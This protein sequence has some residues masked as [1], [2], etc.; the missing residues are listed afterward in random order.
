MISPP[1]VKL[2]TVQNETTWVL[3]HALNLALAQARFTIVLKVDCDYVLDPHVLDVNPLQSSSTYFYSGNWR[4]ARTENDIHLNGAMLVRRDKLAFVAG[5]DERIQTYGWDDTDMYNR[6]QRLGHLIKKDFTYGSI[7]HVSH[8]DSLRVSSSSSTTST[9]T[10]TNN[11][12]NSTTMTRDTLSWL[13]ETTSLPPLQI[14]LNRLFTEK[15][16]LWNST[17]ATSM[18]SRW[19]VAH[20]H[21][22]PTSSS[23]AQGSSPSSRALQHFIATRMSRAPAFTSLVP[24]SK[25]VQYHTQ[26]AFWYLRSRNVPM[27]ITRMLRPMTLFRLIHAFHNTEV[28]RRKDHPPVNGTQSRAKLFVVDVQNGLGNRLRT[29]MS[30]VAFAHTFYRV[31]LI[32]WAP[33]PHCMAKF[34]D[35]FDVEQYPHVVLDEAI[36]PWPFKPNVFPGFQIYNLLDNEEESGIRAGVKFVS[37]SEMAPK[38]FVVRPLSNKHVYMRSPNVINSDVVL[39]RWITKSFQ[40]L[41]PVGEVR[42]MLK[43]QCP[44]DVGRRFGIHMRTKSLEQ[45][46]AGVD[47]GKEYTKRFMSGLAKYKSKSSNVTLFFEEMVRTWNENPTAKFVAASDSSEALE[48]LDALVASRDRSSYLSWNHDACSD[49]TVHC[50]RTALVELICLSRTQGVIGSGWSSFTEVTC[51]M[52]SRKRFF[53]QTIGFGRTTKSMGANC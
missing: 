5:Y 1:K 10:T 3:S 28:R 35:L 46:I 50:I 25:L 32:V 41:V 15:L 11:D 47:P 8:L 27:S 33:N 44:A 45:D 17:L 43:A 6:L 12:K 2:I 52:S 48:K 18:A 53:I 38:N 26:V 40:S 7:V 16:P 19:T 9:T 14:Q 4:Q 13:T 23:V 49:R 22:Q 34:S 30:G 20:A 29:M 39:R 51:R 31:P 37:R 42:D 21:S 24:T 36:A